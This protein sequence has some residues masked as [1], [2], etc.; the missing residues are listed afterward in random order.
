MNNNISNNKANVNNINAIKINND[1]VNDNIVNLDSTSN[2]NK[3]Q[4]LNLYIIIMK[5]IKN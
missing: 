4:K 1:S 5:V 2:I 3:N